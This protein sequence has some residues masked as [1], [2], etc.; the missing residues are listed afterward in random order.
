MFPTLPDQIANYKLK[1]VKNE[2]RRLDAHLKLIEF[3]FLLYFRN[4]TYAH[5]SARISLP[6]GNIT[7][8]KLGDQRENHPEGNFVRKMVRGC[9]RPLWIILRKQSLLCCLDLVFHYSCL[10]FL[11]NF[12]R[13]LTKWQHA[14]YHLKVLDIFFVYFNWNFLLSTHSASA[15][16][17][18]LPEAE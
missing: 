11:Y 2:K 17:P 16:L 13:Q 18:W 9:I 5:L 8:T 12:W 7:I 15:M 3:S 10:L 4:Q 6:L 14:R 1:V